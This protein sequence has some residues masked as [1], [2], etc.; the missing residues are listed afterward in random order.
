MITQ[1]FIDLFAQLMAK[2]VSLFPP[3]PASFG[4]SIA[5]ISGIGSA[6]GSTVA[7]FGVVV[8]FDTINFWSTAFVAVLAAWL[9]V[10]GVKALTWALGR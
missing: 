10:L 1:G 3:I 4:D 9:A 8:P 5:A 6:I 2:L 7:K